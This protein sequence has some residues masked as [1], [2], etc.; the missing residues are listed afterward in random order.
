MSPLIKKPTFLEETTGLSPAEKGTVVHFVM[1]HLKLD[2]MREILSDRTAA[3]KLCGEIEFELGEMVFDEQ[4]TIQQS[5]SVDVHKIAEFLLSPIGLR[6]LKSEKVYRETPFNLEIGCREIYPDLREDLYG[7]E[8]IL[9]QGVIDC[10]FEEENGIIMLDYKTD[11]IPKG[12]S[13]VAKERYVM[14]VGYYSKALERLTGR[15][16]REKYVYLFSSGDM[17]EF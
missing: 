1:Q 2:R 4:L 13:E 11:F 14:Q 10:F 3:H 17:V 8:T 12:N 7:N 6:M 5:K 16:V 15:V 9:L